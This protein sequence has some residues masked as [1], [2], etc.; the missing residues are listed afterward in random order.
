MF[1]CAGL[2]NQF[3]GN[4]F[5]WNSDRLFMTLS[6]NSSKKKHNKDIGM[7]VCATSASITQPSSAISIVELIRSINLYCRTHLK[8]SRPSN[9]SKPM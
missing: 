4:Q 6:V 1:G 3:D 5:E 9:K 2:E 8:I 7:R